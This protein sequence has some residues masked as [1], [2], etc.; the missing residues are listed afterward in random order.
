[1]ERP[2]VNISNIVDN[3][4]A[5]DQR[6]QAGSGNHNVINISQTLTYNNI[7]LLEEGLTFCPANNIFREYE[8]HKDV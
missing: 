1:M 6:E 3:G 2:L 8:Q 4:Q 5:Q 7:K